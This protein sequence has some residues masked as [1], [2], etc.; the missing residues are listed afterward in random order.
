MK[1]KFQRRRRRRRERNLMVMVE[2]EEEESKQN[3]SRSRGGRECLRMEIACSGGI[4]RL[5]VRMFDMASSH[6]SCIVSVVSSGTDIETCQVGD[7]TMKSSK[8]GCSWIK[9]I[10]GEEGP[11]SYVTETGETYN[12]D[13]VTYK[14]GKKVETG[15]LHVLSFPRPALFLQFQVEFFP[16]PPPP[17]PPALT[18]RE[19][20]ERFCSTTET[21]MKETGRWEPRT[22]REST[23]ALTG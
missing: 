9:G 16:P 17:P 5:F 3:N 18:D 21:S 20:Q 4:A 8:E 2:R 6:T 13:Y 19:I 15:Q 1:E 11:F 10:E 22:G 23:N 14:F 7:T 12:V